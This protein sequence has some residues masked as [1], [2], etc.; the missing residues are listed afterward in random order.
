MANSQMGVLCLF[1]QEA[2]ALTCDVKGMSHQF[3]FH[4]EYRDL[5]RFYWWDQGDFK[6]DPE[7][8]RMKVHVFG[9]LY[10]LCKFCFQEG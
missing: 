10:R 7:E 3:F 9:I 6:S 5:L 2:V 4:V 1:C 8:H